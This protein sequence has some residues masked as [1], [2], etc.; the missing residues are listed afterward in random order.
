MRA[1]TWLVQKGYFSSR[2]RA[3]MAIQQGHVQ[4]NGQS[5]KKAS[6]KISEKDRIDITGTPLRYVSRGGLKLEKAIHSFN[7]DFSG[8]RILDAGASTG[9]F[10]DCALQHGATKVYAVDVGV[11]QL[12][13]SLKGHPQVEFFEE[14]DIR[15]FSL[16][17]MGG[18][19]VDII[20][21]D[22]SFVSL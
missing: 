8:K 16:T 15:H 20:V 14:Q 22:L 7:I 4:V 1:D 6:F 11:S 5:I 3:Q 2:Q 9:G 18:Q 19:P 13:D 12:V 10:T 21:G 17:Q